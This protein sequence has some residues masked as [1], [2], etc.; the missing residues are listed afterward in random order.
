VIA[1]VVDFQINGHHFSSLKGNR[2]LRIR[3]RFSIA[4]GEPTIRV[5]P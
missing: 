3:D 2:A 4:S 1:V 5:S